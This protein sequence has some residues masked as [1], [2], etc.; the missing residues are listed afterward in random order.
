LSVSLVCIDARV[1][2]SDREIRELGD[3]LIDSVEGGHRLGRRAALRAQR[4][5]TRR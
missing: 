2:L 3:V 5:A 4:L 1:S